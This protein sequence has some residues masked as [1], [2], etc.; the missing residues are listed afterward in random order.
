VQNGVV[1]VAAKD[2][3]LLWEYR[4]END[5]PD[6]VC[7]TPICQGD[8]VYVTAWGGGSTL[9]KI[10]ADGK[11]F[12]ATEVYSTNDLSN[13]QGGV[14]LVDKHLYG[15]HDT[16]SWVCLD[17]A[18]GMEKWKARR[19][20]AGALTAADGRLYILTEDEDTV[21]LAE[22]SPEALKLVSRFTLPETS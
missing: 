10:A 4:R 17:F 6:V 13:C 1:G 8:Q 21:I 14:V 5:F 2:G 18:T 7:P 16:T 22:A 20:R 15:F 3:A 9:L 11:K 19:P 12:K